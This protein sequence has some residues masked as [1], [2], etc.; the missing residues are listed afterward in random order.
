RGRSI[1]WF[2]KLPRRICGPSRILAA[3]LQ[4]S[5]N[6]SVR[7]VIVASANGAACDRYCGKLPA[8]L[9]E[10]LLLNTGRCGGTHVFHARSE[11]V[12]LVRDVGGVWLPGRW[13]PGRAISGCIHA[14]RRQDRQRSFAG[15]ASCATAA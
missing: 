10:E 9:D 12:V 1:S 3:P 6:G 15:V 13:A 2:T 5:R 4:E 11:E 8:D 7:A 14:Q